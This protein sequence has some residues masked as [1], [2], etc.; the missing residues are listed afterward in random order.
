MA[1]K[2][3]V[4]GNKSKNFTFRITDALSNDIAEI[5]AK[6]EQHGLRLN[7]TEG[8]TAALERELRALQKHIQGIEPSWMPGQLSLPAVD[9]AKAHTKKPRAPRKQAQPKV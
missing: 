1:V 9:S 4:Q 8:L 5:K 7:L 6:C 3:L 2:S